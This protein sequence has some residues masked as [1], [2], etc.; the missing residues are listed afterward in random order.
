MMPKAPEVYNALEKYYKD[1]YDEHAING[2]IV[3]GCLIGTVAILIMCVL[4][5]K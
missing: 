1:R 4:I 3:A 2:L 5:I